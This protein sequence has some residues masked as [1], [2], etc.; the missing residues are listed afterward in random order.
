MRVSDCTGSCPIT[1]ADKQTLPK[2]LGR[3]AGDVCGTLLCMNT[4]RPGHLRFGGV[5]QLPSLGAACSLLSALVLGGCINPTWQE[6]EITYAEAPTINGLQA[7]TLNVESPKGSG[8]F[9]AIIM[10][11]GGGWASGDLSTYDAFTKRVKRAGFV[12]VNINYRLSRLGDDG[13]PGAVWPA[14]VQ[15]VRCAARWLTSN[16]QHLN[17]DPSRVGIMGDS[18][19][20]HLAMMTAYSLDDP[21]FDASFCKHRESVRINAVGSLFGVS[22]L[23][24]AYHTGDWYIKPTIVNFLGL[25]DGASPESAPKRFREANPTYWV[26]RGPRLPT[27]I[28]H[29]S[30][31]TL[32]PPAVQESFA[33]VAQGAD[34]DVQLE[35]VDG[36]GHGLGSDENFENACDRLLHWFEETL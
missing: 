16:A 2:K 20:G 10:V 17:V 33:S 31:D 21:T 30:A 25:P 24:V 35:Y 7:L 18:A 32:I 14:H 12:A 8:P 22:D 27:Y 36:V 6:G 15:D 11:H 26:A 23:I 29:G 3:N 19:G 13:Q 28:I 34:L 9:P 4:I 5:T 1:G